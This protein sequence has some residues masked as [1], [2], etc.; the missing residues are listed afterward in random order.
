[1][2]TGAMSK[3]ATGTHRGGAATHH[4]SIRSGRRRSIFPS[5]RVAFVHADADADAAVGVA[6]RGL[7]YKDNRERRRKHVVVGATDLPGLTV[8]LS[9]RQRGETLI[10]DD[11]PGGSLGEG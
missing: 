7:A 9:H 11:G 6:P 1:M 10:T 4:T 8:V 5:S 3:L 2:A